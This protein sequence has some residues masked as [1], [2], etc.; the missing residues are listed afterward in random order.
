MK[1]LETT[2]RFQK[3]AVSFL[4]LSLFMLLHFSLN[5]ASADSNLV[6]IKEI[7]DRPQSYQLH[8]VTLHGTVTNLQKVTPYA[9]YNGATFI[10]SSLFTLT[11]ETGSIQVFIQG[12]CCSRIPLPPE[13]N[14]GEAVFVEATVQVTEPT[15]FPHELIGADQGVRVLVQKIWR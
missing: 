6:T 2:N 14:E 1:G 15:M 12:I 5:I 3:H 13:V 10:N 11:D 9:D 4:I 7:L 8:T